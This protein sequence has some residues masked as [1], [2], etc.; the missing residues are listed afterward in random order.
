M[1]E[2]RLSPLVE[3]KR[4]EILLALFDSK[5]FA[6]EENAISYVKAISDFI[7]SVPELRHRP[8]KK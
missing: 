6:M 5:Y 1:A 3:A 7:Q 8:T 4:N 2:I